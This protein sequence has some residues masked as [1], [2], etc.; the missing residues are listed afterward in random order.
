MDLAPQTSVRLVCGFCMWPLVRGRSSILERGRGELAWSHLLSTKMVGAPRPLQIRSSETW[1]PVFDGTS[2][3]IRAR[4]SPSENWSAT[5]GKRYPRLA[6]VISL[7]QR[8]LLPPSA[9][10]LESNK[11]SNKRV[12]CFVSGN[13]RGVCYVHNNPHSGTGSLCII[14]YSAHY[15]K[16]ADNR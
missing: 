8:R 3:A 2:T 16:H 5:W 7:T 6:Y 15:C 4:G 12:L 1:S 14:S 9:D 13:K 10:W 11:R